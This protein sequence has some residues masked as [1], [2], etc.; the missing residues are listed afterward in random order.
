MGLSSFHPTPP[1]E[2]GTPPINQGST[3]FSFGVLV[4]FYYAF[5][6]PNTF[7]RHLRILLTLLSLGHG[8]DTMLVEHDSPSWYDTV[9]FEHKLS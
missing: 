7:V 6:A 3:P 2:Q 9:H 1:L 5:E 4:I 8:F